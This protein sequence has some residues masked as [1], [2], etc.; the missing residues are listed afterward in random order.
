MMKKALTFAAGAASAAILARWLSPAADLHGA[1]VLVT[2]GSRGLGLVLCRE[3]A[4]RGARIVLCA[5]DEEEVLRARRDLES[6]G[7]EVLALVCD[8]RIP[9]AAE[10]LVEQAVARFG[11]LDVV[12]NNAGIIQV[13]PHETMSLNDFQKAMATNFWG[14]VH[15]T[16]PAL[17]HLRRSSVRRV[18]NIVSIGGA[19]SVPH[20]LPYSCAK[21]ALRGFSEGLG[22]ELAGDRI[23]VTTVLPWLMRTG[24]FVNA[25][26]KGKREEELAWFSLGATTPLLSLSAERA[27][28]RIVVAC[29]R[30]EAF[31]TLGF[32]G[33]A[34]RIAHSLAPGMTTRLLGLVNSLLPGP[35][36]AGPED[37]AEPGWQHR[38]PINEPAIRDAGERAARDN[39]EL[40]YVPA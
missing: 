18:V 7:A 11:G 10:R 30:G 4:R 33:K 37:P 13:G 8:V 35:G 29:E 36:G 19:I 17:P 1:V 31:V 3:L 27:A 25:L 21:F 2:G 23:R 15:V 20:L 39:N 22:A 28:R 5:R 6:R 9:A 40:G 24:S 14:A 38:S 26:F 12:V 16:L 34:L 32:A